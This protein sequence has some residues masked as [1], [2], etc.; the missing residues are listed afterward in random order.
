MM[1]KY[2]GKGKDPQ[3]A[4]MLIQVRKAASTSPVSAPTRT[5]LDN[6]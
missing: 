2:K 1:W 6:H 4:F 3:K 5:L